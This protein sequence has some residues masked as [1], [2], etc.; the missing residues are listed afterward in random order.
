VPLRLRD[1]IRKKPRFATV[2]ELEDFL[3]SRAAFM[4]QKCIYEYARARSGVLSAKLF[5]EPAFRAA[6]EAASWRNYPLALQNVSLMAERALRG[7]AGDEAGA[8]RQGLAATVRAVCRRYPVP[9][10][11]AGDFWPAAA[12]RIAA[13]I[14]RAGLAAPREVKDIP[15]ETAEEFFAGLPIHP[16]LR[17]Y[18]YELVTNNLRVNLCRAH[19]EFVA[20]ADLGRLAGLLAGGG[21]GGAE[22]AADERA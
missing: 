14:H 8:M 9:R 6:V 22:M 5:R 19:E 2:G 11:M 20:T 21:H 13:R 4:A 3:D 17:Q 1:L 18:D 15:Q 10:D 12:E 7:P 16:D